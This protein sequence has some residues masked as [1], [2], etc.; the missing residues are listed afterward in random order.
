LSFGFADIL[1]GRKYHRASKAGRR[2][3]ADHSFRDFVLDQLARIEE[4]T[5]VRMFGGFGLYKG[6]IF[7]GIISSGRLYFLTDETTRP[8]YEARGMQPFRPTEKQTL[9]SYYEVPLDVLEDDAR[10]T[11]WANRAAL[12]RRPGKQRVKRKASGTGI[13]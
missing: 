10:L 1:I 7:F 4:L 11:S 6:Q 12:C 8:E 13:S 9:T 5:C 3:T 2:M